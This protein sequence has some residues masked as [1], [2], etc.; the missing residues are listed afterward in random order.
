MQKTI[1]LAVLIISHIVCAAAGAIV[2]NDEEKTK[3][4]NGGGCVLV[5]MSVVAEQ[6][7]SAYE[8]GLKKGRART[9]GLEA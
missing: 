2:L 8:A 4:L 1:K 3:C 6:V 9:C 7:K 5:P